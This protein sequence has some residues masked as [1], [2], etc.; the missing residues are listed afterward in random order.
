MLRYCGHERVFLLDG[1][2]SGWV[3]AGLPVTSGDGNLIAARGVS[4]ARSF[5]AQVQSGWTVDREQVRAAIDQ[6]ETVIVDSRS[7]ERHRGEVEP[8][9][10]Y[11]GHIPG[12]IDRFWQGVTDEAGF[13]KLLET[14]WQRWQAIAAL[15]P[16]RVI[17]YCGSGVTACVNLLSFELAR[18]HDPTLAIVPQLCAGS[19]SDWCAYATSANDPTIARG[20]DAS[21]SRNGVSRS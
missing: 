3:A 5:V 13:A 1:G 2:F 10:P 19:W 8:I 21:G 14:Q 18:Q 4:S 11:A 6:A 20:S 17:V 15:S 9:D 16:D 12:A 7:P